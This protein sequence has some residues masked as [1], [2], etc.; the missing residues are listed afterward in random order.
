MTLKGRV[1]LVTGA[2][3]GIGFEIARQIGVCGAAV[4]LVDLDGSRLQQAREEFLSLGLQGST[5]EADVSD[6]GAVE[7]LTGE[8]L[9]EKGHIDILVNNA[10]VVRDKLLVAMD[11]GSWDKVISVNL[12]GAFN[13]TRFVARAM[14]RER[15]GRIVNISSVVGL[16]GNAGQANYSASKAGLIG[17][18]KSVARELASRGV[19]V[20]AIA[21]G[22]IKTSMTD[23][24]PEKVKEDMLREIPLGRFGEPSDV[25]AVVRFLVSD[26]AGYITGQVINV[27]GGMV[28]Q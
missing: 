6:F 17:F 12:K 13:C 1:A 2:A 20:N 28:M 14:A 27:D 7:K 23:A 24:L 3:Q 25:A 8:I 4:V 18:T 11:E 19:T 21:P 22:F 16:K 26:A 5:R 9:E 10:G 15:W